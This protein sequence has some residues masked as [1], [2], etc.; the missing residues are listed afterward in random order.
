MTS[1]TGTAGANVTSVVVKCTINTVTVGG[2]I[3]GLAGNGLVLTE[4]TSSGTA[5]PA[6]AA[7]SFTI[8]PTVNVG[9]ATRLPS[10][11]SRPIHHRPA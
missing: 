6:A 4:T 3:T 7:T 9:A 5:S 11:L 8:A 1:G 10:P 2:T